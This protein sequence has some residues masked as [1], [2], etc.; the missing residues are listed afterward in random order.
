MALLTDSMANG[1]L[2][3]TGLQHK[4]VIDGIAQPYPVYKIRLDQLFYNPH[5]D[6][7]ATWMSKYR[8]ENGGDSLEAL[9]R[10]DFN[11]IVEKFIIDS[12]SDA[13]RQTT[14]NIKLLGQRVPAIV[15][16]NGLIIDGNRRFTCLR[17]LSN[18]DARFNWIEA[19]VLPE[20]I[21]S[22]QKRI[23]ILELTI[24]HG[25]EEKVGYDP[26]DRLVGIYFDVIKNGL[27]SEEEY[28]KYINASLPEVRKM[29]IQATLMND[30]LS[31]AD[32]E[33]KY[34]LARELGIY[35]PLVE[36]PAILKNCADE[37]E[38]EIVKNA[39]FANLIVAPQGDM[40]RFV[41]KF[42][43]ILK[44]PF[45]KEFLEWESE[46][47]INVI[48]KLNALDEVTISTIRE[49]IRSDNHLVD[50]MSNAVD[51][52]EAKAKGDRV[53]AAPIDNILAAA[54]LLDRVDT[55]IMA[56]LKDDDQKKAIRALHGIVERSE[57][58]MTNM[59]SI[60]GLYAD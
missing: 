57:Q 13:I 27:L 8:S 59:D 50:S 11:T 34:Y 18:D 49:D 52:F 31:F 16:D 55:M 53:L 51:V 60:E 41:R 5:N 38:Q 37:D 43:S 7:I 4:L 56:H 19:I 33:E 48:D 35:G 6:R 21:A 44:S 39:I 47:A 29:V 1:T 28:A 40:T 26:I 20:S 9:E 2:L 45:A 30:F 42:K 36:I 17:K 46:L 23:K 22:D 58:I 3:E 15:L 14:N 25:E 10:D 54:D 32:A 12:N 24:Q